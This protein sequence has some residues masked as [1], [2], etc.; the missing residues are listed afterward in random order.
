[1]PSAMRFRQPQV[2]FSEILRL[3][4]CARLDMIVIISSPLLSSVSMFSYSNA[5]PTPF[6]LSLRMVVR[7]STV[8]RAK[9][10]TDLVMI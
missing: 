10:L 5:T 3:S 7:L 1:M 8:F 9:R 2:T 4:S 6:S